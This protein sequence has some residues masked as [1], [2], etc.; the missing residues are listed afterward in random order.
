MKETYLIC[1]EGN[2]LKSI[3]SYNVSFTN[4]I[5]EASFLEYED[6]LKTV[7]NLIM[8]GYEAKAVQYT[9]N[10]IDDESKFTKKG[11]FAIKMNDGTYW[12]WDYYGNVK[13]SPVIEK[14]V[15]LD[16]YKDCKNRI[17]FQKL[18]GKAVQIIY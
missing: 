18:N 14:N 1:V 3:D 15:F 4:E 13:T 7:N 11:L 17:K 5:K 9:Y 8:L 2:Y 6:A 12:T 16:S 10:E